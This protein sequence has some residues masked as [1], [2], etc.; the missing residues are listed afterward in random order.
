M[1][2]KWQ[3]LSKISHFPTKGGEK[4]VYHAVLRQNETKQTKKP[5]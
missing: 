4:Q 5:K 1:P 2:G 3:L